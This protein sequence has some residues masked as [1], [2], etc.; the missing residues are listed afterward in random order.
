MWRKKLTQRRKDAKNG[1]KR[2]HS[3]ILYSVFSYPLR[4]RA[5]A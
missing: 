4:L 5:F 3:L 2:D 1:K